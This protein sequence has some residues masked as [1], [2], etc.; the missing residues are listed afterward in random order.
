MSEPTRPDLE[1]DAFLARFF[2]IVVVMFL[3]VMGFYVGTIVGKQGREFD[4]QPKDLLPGVTGALAG[5]GIAAVINSFVYTWYTKVV[6][7]DS[8]DEWYGPQSGHNSGH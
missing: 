6:K 8:E 3:T 2:G 1:P 7:Q 4:L 5:F